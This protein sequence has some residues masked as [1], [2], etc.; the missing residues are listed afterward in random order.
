MT[1]TE[2]T[3]QDRGGTLAQ[4]RYIYEGVSAKGRFS[5]GSFYK[6]NVMDLFIEMYMFVKGVL[7]GK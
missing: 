4:L 3:R 7:N 5:F 1:T 6:C 2:S